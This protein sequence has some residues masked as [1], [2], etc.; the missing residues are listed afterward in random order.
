MQRIVL[1]GRVRQITHDGL[2]KSFTVTNETSQQVTNRDASPS[3]ERCVRAAKLADEWE[4][5]DRINA[6]GM[7]AAKTD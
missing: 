6:I 2:W 1:S 3:S 5:E 7:Q 4:S